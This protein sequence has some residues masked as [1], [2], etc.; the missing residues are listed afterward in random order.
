VPLNTCTT[1]NRVFPSA[2]VLA[3]DEIAGRCS[4]CTKND[5]LRYL[6]NLDQEIRGSR[7]VT[8]EL[9]ED[10]GALATLYNS[11]E[12]TQLHQSALLRWAFEAERSRQGKVLAYL[13]QA[14]RNDSATLVRNTIKH[15]LN[16][17]VAV[18][19]IMVDGQPRFVV[20]V[21]G[22]EAER[23]SIDF[24][25]ACIPDRIAGVEVDTVTEM[26]VHPGAMTRLAHI[27]QV[28]GWNWHAEQKVLR[29]IK[30]TY[31]LMARTTA[32]TMGI[33]HVSGPCTPDSAGEGT[34]YC[35]HY[36]NTK[37]EKD[38]GQVRIGGNAT[39]GVAAYWYRG[40]QSSQAAT[41]AGLS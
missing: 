41:L 22:H 13:A 12:G 40:L 32:T 29:Y 34:N 5:A 18:T 31:G 39:T 6:D 21:N 16:V 17:V 7:V 8:S 35:F 36:L 1:C 11:V 33:A 15:E 30:N 23:S 24:I 4:E 38:E 25:R 37:F 20:G 27:T 14:I 28:T 2:D 9:F 3:P 19:L 10:T 26:E